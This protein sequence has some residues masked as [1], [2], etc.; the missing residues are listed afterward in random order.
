MNSDLVELK[1]WQD[2]QKTQETAL[3]KSFPIAVFFF[4][5]VTQSKTILK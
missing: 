3:I 4:A 1:A 2:Q 5:D